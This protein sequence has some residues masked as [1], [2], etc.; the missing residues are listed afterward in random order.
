MDNG[1]ARHPLCLASHSSFNPVKLNGRLAIKAS[2]SFKIPSFSSSCRVPT[3][4]LLTAMQL[5]LFWKDM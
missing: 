5:F 2:K 4:V 3:F 1:E